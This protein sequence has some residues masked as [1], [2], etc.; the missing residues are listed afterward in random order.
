M[1]EQKKYD[2]TI[3]VESRALTVAAYKHIRIK[4]KNNRK[5]RDII[6]TN[7]FF[8]FKFMTNMIFKYISIIK[9][10]NFNTQKHRLH[11]NDVIYNY[12][13]S[14]FDH[15]FTKNNTEIFIENQHDV[16]FD[17]FFLLHQKSK[18]RS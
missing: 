5:F 18:M 4:H 9:E 10:L 3:I 17:S 12:A 11:K 13:R 2:Q 14:K 7:V 1:K 6:L 8:I 15:Y 16:F